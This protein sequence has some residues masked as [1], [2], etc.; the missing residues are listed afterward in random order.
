MG[1]GDAGNNIEHGNWLKRL[2]NGRV[3]MDLP[4]GHLVQGGEGR[5]GAGQAAAR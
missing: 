4:P 3:T 2:H 1:G 5:A